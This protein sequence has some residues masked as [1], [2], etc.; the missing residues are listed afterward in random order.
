MGEQ[1]GTGAGRLHA[2]TGA[3]LAAFLASTSGSSSDKSATPLRVRCSTL[4]F[5]RRRVPSSHLAGRSPQLLLTVVGAWGAGALLA[6]CFLATCAAAGIDV[7]QP[8]LLWCIFRGSMVGLRYCPLPPPSTRLPT[9]RCASQQVRPE[10]Q[11]AHHSHSFA[12]NRPELAIFPVP[13][14]GSDVREVI[15]WRGC[16]LALT[17]KGQGAALQ[18]RRGNHT[19]AH[20]DG[21][22]MTSRAELENLVIVRTQQLRRSCPRIHKYELVCWSC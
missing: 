3:F 10:F 18:P 17:E 5:L 6:L 4:P 2:D 16:G 20:Q 13:W 22:L 19:R 1:V 7:G 14:P 11:P 21:R 8:W 9:V 15:F 12:L